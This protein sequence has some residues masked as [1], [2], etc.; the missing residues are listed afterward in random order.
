MTNRFKN[1]ILYVHAA[2]VR[3]SCWSLNLHVTEIFDDIRQLYSFHTPD[4]KLGELIEFF[5]QSSSEKTRAFANNHLFDVRMFASWTPTIWIN[6]GTPY[7]LL[8]GNQ[9]LELGAFDDVLLLRDSTVTRINQPGDYIFTIKLFPGSL[10]YFFDISPTACR[11][12]VLPATT[13][14]PSSLVQTI[15]QLPGF[16]QRVDLLEKFFLQKL[17]HRKLKDYYLQIA[18]NSIELCDKSS[19]NYNTSAIAERL[20]VSSKSINRYFQK[21]VGIS[22]KKYFSVLRA[23]K[24]LS[25]FVSDRSSF[26]AEEFG[27]YDMSHF[28]RDMVRFTGQRMM[29]PS[30]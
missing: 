22:P 8:T 15:R 20:F 9:T 24:A 12:L 11:N 23:R 30:L 16:N 4:G 18:R 6:L 28:Y 19:L 3:F 2:K 25:A 26:L 21:A 10:E 14:L 13:V 7:R 27:Y 17:A 5:S 1:I 29:L